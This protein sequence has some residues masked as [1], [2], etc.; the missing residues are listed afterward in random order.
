MWSSK[1]RLQILIAFALLL[2]PFLLYSTSAPRETYGDSLIIG[3]FIEPAFINPILTHSSISAALKRIVFDGLIK[4]NDKMEPDPHLARSW[5]NSPDGKTWVFQL[6]SDVKFHNGDE[7]T[8]EDV[9]F[10]FDKIKDPSTNSPYFSVFENFKA[11][12]VKNRYTVEIDLRNPLPSLPF[13]LDVGILPKRLLMGKDLMMADFNYHP[14]GTGPFKIESWSKDEI[15]MRAHEDHFGG[16]PHLN[17]VVVKFFDDQRVVW[18][19]LMKG[20]VDC[21][22]LTYSKNYDIIERIPDLNVYSFLNPYYYMLAFNREN[23]I[24][25]SRKVRQALNYAVDKETLLKKVLRGKGRLSSGTIYPQSWA[26]SKSIEPYPYDQ[27]MASILLEEAGWQDTNGN[28]VLDKNGRELEFVLFIVDGDDVA[29]ACALLM[30][31]QLLDTGIK[32]VVKPLPFSGMYER[33]LSTKKFDAAL[34]SIISDDPDKNY[35]WW[36]SSQIDH[37]FNVFSYKNNKIDELLDKGRTTLDKEERKKIYRQFQ[38]EIYDDPPGVFLFWRD[39]LIGVHRRFK[40]VRISPAGILNH[41][42]EWH[43]PKGEQKYR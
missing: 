24:F 19:E 26:Y 17:R 43:V 32:M 13:Y 14:I 25:T 38:M 21:V 20:T 1:V 41:I 4:I 3:D 30:Q 11:V 40:G 16:R 15:I 8:A 33:F 22:F 35:A 27:K 39:Y 6:K 31:Q 2:T 42:N 12:N 36:H 28:H 7:L 34:L 18:A 23:A 29:E 5:E 9:K 10:T 37:G